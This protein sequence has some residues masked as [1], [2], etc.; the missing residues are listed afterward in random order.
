M[1]GGCCESDGIEKRS[2]ADGEHVGMPVDVTEI[3]LTPDLTDEILIGLAGLAAGE[4]TD[5]AEVDVELPEV[6]VDLIGEAFP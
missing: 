6:G 4:D 3:D 1:G 2:A 5:A